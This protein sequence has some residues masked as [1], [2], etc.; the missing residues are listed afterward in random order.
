MNILI[1]TCGTSSYLSHGFPISVFVFQQTYDFLATDEDNA[2]AATGAAVA[3]DTP[4]TPQER[5]QTLATLL[6]SFGQ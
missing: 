6:G 3:T 5:R 4:Q 1:A 2:A